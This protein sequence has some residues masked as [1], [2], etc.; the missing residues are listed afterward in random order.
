[1]VKL[2]RACAY[3]RVSTLLDKQEVSLSSQVQYYNEMFDNDPELI[4]AGIYIDQGISGKTISRRREFQRMIRDCREGKID[5]VYCKSITRF[6]R[7]TLDSLKT[8]ELFKSLGI[9]VIFDVEGINTLTDKEFNTAL[10]S[11]LAEDEV[12]KDIELSNAWVKKAQESGKYTRLNSILG[13]N[14]DTVNK[15]LTVNPQEAEVVRRIFDLY[16]K[17]VQSREIVRILNKE[18]LT[19]FRNM[20]FNSSAILRI[21]HQ[22]K[23]TG[24]MLLAKY[25]TDKHGMRKINHG[26][27]RQYFVENT[28]EAIISK[29][30][31]DKAQEVCKS[32]RLVQNNTI[33][34]YDP[35]RELVYCGVCGKHFKR[36]QCNKITNPKTRVS[37]RCLKCVNEGPKACDN[38]EAVRIWTLKSGFVATFNKLKS[39]KL[40]FSELPTTTETQEIDKEL[41]GMLQQEKIY[42][43]MN[44]NGLLTPALSK[45]YKILVE[46]IVALQEKKKEICKRSIRYNELNVSANI[47]EDIFN[48]FDEL[49]EFDDGAFTNLIEKVV[50]HSRNE[51]EYFYKIGISVTIRYIH[52]TSIDDEIT[53][54]IINE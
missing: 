29:E 44:I 52:Y 47:A 8:I 19:T 12:D 20:K 41:E 21:I 34:E 30:V 2:K 25:Y 11:Y 6:G 50:V 51:I 13:Y 28:H 54:V 53:E 32:R 5:V 1:M 42:I 26:E 3:C 22:E 49:K 38:H 7:N 16:I 15:V 46:K 39:V 14:W 24:N 9:P 23:Y 33:K 35:F 27:R 36:L 31:F 37:Y 48:K 4:N 10:M 43:H 17:G 45:D 18:G 40:D